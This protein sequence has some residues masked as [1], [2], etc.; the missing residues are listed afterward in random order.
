MS[1]VY[2][3]QALYN[4]NNYVCGVAYVDVATNKCTL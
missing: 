4:Q 2:P 3:P 1:V